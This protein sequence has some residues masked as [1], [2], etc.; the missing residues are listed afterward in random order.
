MARWNEPATYAALV[1]RI[2]MA[3]VFLWFG[4][5]QIR[6]PSMFSFYV[7]DWVAS[8]AGSAELASFG[9]GIAE[10]ILAVLL[11]VGLGTRIVA[12]LLALH[13]A[14]ITVVIGF[15]ATGVR[16][17]GL[18]VATTALVLHGKDKWCLDTYLEKRFS[19]TRKG[20]FLKYLYT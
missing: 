4:V 8:L 6:N 7:P 18:T 17:F 11:I 16:D 1:L 13:L 19:G 14:A 10:V 2:G 5:T 3:L 20:R 15:N 12:A 9:N